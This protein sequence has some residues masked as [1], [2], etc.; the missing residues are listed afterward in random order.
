MIHMCSYANIVVSERRDEAS[1]GCNS[2]VTKIN[3]KMSEITKLNCQRIRIERSLEEKQ[4]LEGIAQRAGAWVTVINFCD[5]LGMNYK[6]GVGITDIISFIQDLFDKA[7]K[8]SSAECDSKDSVITNQCNPVFKDGD[9]VYHEIAKQVSLVTD[10]PYRV[11]PYINE[12]YVKFANDNPGLR[13]AT[14]KEVKEYLKEALTRV[15]ETHEKQLAPVAKNTQENKTVFKDRD[16]AWSEW[17]QAPVLVT[18]EEEQITTSTEVTI[19]VANNSPGIYTRHAT[20]KEITD[21]II[22]RN[23]DGN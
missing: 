17:L 23:K 14:K 7:N 2:Q 1:E 13:F 9:W 4:E 8:R 16:W 3:I 21:Y 11:I 18:E 6:H 20:K 15:R 22:K 5:Q 19:S 12:S 10:E